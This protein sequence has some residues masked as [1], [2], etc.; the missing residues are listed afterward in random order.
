[1]AFKLII[2]LLGL[3]LTGLVVGRCP[4]P[5]TLQ[6]KVKTNTGYK[7][8]CARLYDYSH[9]D[10]LLS[11]TGKSWDVLNGETYP[12]RGRDG[13][14][15]RVSSLVV[16]PGC[17]LTAYVHGQFR[18]DANEYT[19][20]F[21]HLGGWNNYMSS[22]TCY[23]PYSDVPLNC[24]PEDRVVTVNVCHNPNSVTMTCHYAVQKGIVLGSSVTQGKS[25]STAVEVSMGA[26]FKEIFS[27]GLS[28]STTTTHDWSSSQSEEF[29]E[30]TTHTVTCDVP[31]GSRL[32][33]KQ[34]V[35]VCG[36]TNVYSNEYRCEVLTD[37]TNE[38]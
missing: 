8:L 19:G 22:W 38:G 16:R 5:E 28:V 1:M 31:G 34:V 26:V 17:T 32:A 27:V 4:E 35:G 11:C 7:F 37:A 20:I 2:I 36:D 14:N 18:G 10:R 9:Y 33:V 13:W 15:D 3:S 29:S 12:G 24:R 23:C 21:S 6:Y 30:V 25:V